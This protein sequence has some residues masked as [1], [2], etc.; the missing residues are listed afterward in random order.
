MALDQGLQNLLREYDNSETSWGGVNNSDLS[1]RI[2]QYVA[3]NLSS[4][5]IHSESFTKDMQD[6]SHTMYTTA[7]LQ[8]FPAPWPERICKNAVRNLRKS[9]K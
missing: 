1:K 5:Y 9:I 3:D 4:H 2:K 7:Q 8:S 6:F